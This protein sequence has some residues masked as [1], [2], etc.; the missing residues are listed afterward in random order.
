MAHL[1]HGDW[2]PDLAR[3][4][5]GERQGP[6]GGRR[7]CCVSHAGTE[8]DS[9]TGRQTGCQCRH[10]GSG[11][12]VAGGVTPTQGGR[13]M[14]PQGEGVSTSGL[15]KAGS[16]STRLPHGP[17]RKRHARR[18]ATRRQLSQCGTPD[19]LKGAWPVWGGLGGNRRKVWRPR[20]TPSPARVS[21][22]GCD[23]PS[24]Q[25]WL[26]EAS[27]KDTTRCP[28]SGILRRCAGRERRVQSLWTMDPQSAD[29][30]RNRAGTLSLSAPRRRG[31]RMDGRANPGERS[32]NIVTENQPTVRAGLSPKGTVAGPRTLPFLVMGT[33]RSRWTARAY[34]MRR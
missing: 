11:P 31:A 2:L 7:P 30:R 10:R 16:G 6:Y 15:T 4:G 29:W 27:R 13:A 8:D 19:A 21:T 32:R 26:C 34:P 20:S 28:I 24:S 23:M 12:V 3:Q 9:P 18:A 25:S 1:I 5:E 17:R 33:T 22:E 14:L